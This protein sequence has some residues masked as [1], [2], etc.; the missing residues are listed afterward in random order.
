MAN[1]DRLPDQ[2][3]IQQV[4]DDIREHLI[5]PMGQTIELAKQA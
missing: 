5:A 2:L 3:E 1:L 4:R